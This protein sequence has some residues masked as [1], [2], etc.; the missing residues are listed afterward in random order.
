MNADL[1]KEWNKTSELEIN[2][3]NERESNFIIKNYIDV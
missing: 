3:K 1:L 2:N